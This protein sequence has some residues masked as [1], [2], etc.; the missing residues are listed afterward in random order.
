[1]KETNSP[2]PICRL[3]FDSA[4]N[5]A[6]RRLERQRTLAY[7]DRQGCAASGSAVASAVLSHAYR[8]DRSDERFFAARS[9]RNARSVPLNDFGIC[10]A[11]GQ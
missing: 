10:N 7:V 5:L 8:F 11:M 1:M 6:V 2:R 9:Q 4:S 3:T